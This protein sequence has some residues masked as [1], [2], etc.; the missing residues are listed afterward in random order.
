[1]NF[2]FTNELAK[3][4]LTNCDKDVSFLGFDC[5]FTRKGASEGDGHIF[6]MFHEDCKADLTHNEHSSHLVQ[7][8]D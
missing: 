1:M 7:I 2:S 3:Q 4:E 5:F 8:L 6:F